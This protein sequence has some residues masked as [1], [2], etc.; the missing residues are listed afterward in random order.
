MLSANVSLTPFPNPCTN[1]H[2]QPPIYEFSDFKFTKT[3]F[4]DDVDIGAYD[5]YNGT[6]D[7][8]LSDIANNYT[9]FCNWGYQEWPY[10]ETNKWEGDNCVTSN[11]EAPPD[12]SRILT[13]LNLDKENLMRNNKS[14]SSPI[15]IAQFWYCDIVNGSYPEAYQAR[16]EISLDLTC[17]SSGLRSKP[18]TCTIKT[19]LPVRIKAQWLP[20]GTSYPNTPKLAQRPSPSVTPKGLDPPPARDCTDVSFAYPD[21]YLHDFTYVYPTVANDP[22][23][24]RLNFTISSRVTGARVRC[25]WGKAFGVTYRD[26]KVGDYY[27]WPS[28]DPEA[29]GADPFQSQTVYTMGYNRDSRTLK[30]E[31][32]WICGDTSGRYSTKF[33]AE[34]K[35][36]AGVGNF[37]N[38]SQARIP[39]YCSGTI[40]TA[41]PMLI[42]GRLT[43]PV[44][45]T[46]AQLPGP[47]GANTPHCLFNSDLRPRTWTIE[48]FLW[49]TTTLSMHP[50]D[51]IDYLWPYPWNRTLQVTI[52]NAATGVHASCT[53]THASLDGETDTWWPCYR[54]EPHAPPVQRIVE[55]YI[56]FSARTGQLAINQTWYCNDT[57]VATPYEITAYGRTPSFRGLACG[58]SN[59]T[60]VNAPC[61]YVPFW[62]PIG[63][64]CD[65]T[66]S[67][68]WCTLGDRDGNGEALWSWYCDDKDRERPIVFNGTWN[69]YLPLNCSYGDGIYCRFSQGVKEVGVTPTVTHFVSDRLIPDRVPH[70]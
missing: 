29:T 39:L 68:K 32:E 50:R 31:Q 65:F 8:R 58:N 41:D 6:I 60:W 42:E 34:P 48:H 10:D 30:V 62:G 18:E 55:T 52:R 28:C 4:R 56:Q 46:P 24:A 14:L 38:E 51:G 69:G 45:F 3:F 11:G 37:P 12:G 67:A 25:Y 49:Q 64:A 36:Q 66:Y 43:K 7:F 27:M 44:H 61:P 26:L 21:W 47:E 23:T 9:L 16:A 15:K 17:P 35:F 40:C 33:A 13:L 19:Q 2:F 53:F 1:S 5:S 70:W 20:R 57:Q 22:E 59:S 63:T 54:L